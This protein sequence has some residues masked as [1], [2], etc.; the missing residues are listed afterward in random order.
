MAD[1]NIEDKCIN[2]NNFNNIDKLSE[3]GIIG[4][5]DT[6]YIIDLPSNDSIE[7][8]LILNNSLGIKPILAYNHIFNIENRLLGIFIS[9]T[10][11]I[12]MA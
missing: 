8:A 12:F 7:Y 10:L 2:M 9:V 1:M 11:I 5:K 4:Q 3:D 6:M